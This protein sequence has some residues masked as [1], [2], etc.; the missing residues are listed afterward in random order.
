MNCTAVYQRG[1]SLLR[2]TL[3]PNFSVIADTIR[4]VLILIDHSAINQ[5]SVQNHLVPI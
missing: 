3:A 2:N 4:N 5:S 1:G